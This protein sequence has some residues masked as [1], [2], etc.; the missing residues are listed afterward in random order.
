MTNYDN[1]RRDFVYENLDSLISAVRSDGINLSRDK[2]DKI[3]VEIRE[4]KQ[5]LDDVYSDRCEEEAQRSED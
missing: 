4:F 2:Q 5:F 3:E 1:A